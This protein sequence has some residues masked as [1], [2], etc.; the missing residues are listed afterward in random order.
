M[1]FFDKDDQAE[2]AEPARPRRRG[3]G[4]GGASSPEL[5]GPGDGAGRPS[6]QQI[7]SRQLTF[8]GISIVILIL[9]VL[10]FRS[11]QEAR[12]ERGFKNYVSDLSALTT[13]TDQLSKQFFGAL[14]GK[15]ENGDISL[16]NQINGDRGAAQSLMDRAQNLDAPDEVGS[17]QSDIVRSYELRRDALDAIAEQLPR[18]QGNQGAQK[19]TKAIAARMEVF[20]ASDVLFSI[21][22]SGIENE[23]ANE[24]IVV[25]GGVP[26]SEFLPRGNNQPD[27]LD[28]TTVSDA[29]AGAGTDGGG[30]EPANCGSDDGQLHGLGLVSTTALPSGVALTDG[31][32]ATI[33]AEG[34]EFEVAVQNQGDADETDVGVSLSGDFSGSETI[35]SIAAGETQTV[36]ITPRP[37]P[38]AGD[39][40]SL[41]VKVDTV[42]GEQ[43]AEN[44]ET[45]TPYELTF[46]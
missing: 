42:C 2:N 10:A 21:A 40:G 22:R 30:S 14:E 16:Q 18:A 44:N 9:L 23:L 34:A 8:A 28:P 31:A 39:T 6:R 46:E 25:D 26:E 24:E 45:A 37:A 7:R 43:V 17:S 1:D 5:G 36:T 12:Q 41:S 20:L 33:P 29:I 35:P 32:A 19:A 13:E 4:S 3:S 38:S 27:W 11:C 15:S